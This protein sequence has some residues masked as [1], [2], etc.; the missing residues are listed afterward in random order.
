MFDQRKKELIQSVF[1]MAQIVAVANHK[2][3]V[4]KTTT[5]LNLGKALSL[6]GKKVLLIDIDPQANLTQAVGMDDVGVSIIGTFKEDQDLPLVQLAE[7]FFLAPS[8]LDL[9]VVETL[10]QSSVSGY[11]KLRNALQKVQD[12]FDYVLIDCPP[13]LN[14]LTINALIA[15]NMVMV[16]IQSEYLAVRGLTTLQN[17]IEETRKNLNP[18]LRLA[19]ILITQYDK[20]TVVKRA[21]AENVQATYKDLVFSTQIRYNVTLSE[22]ALA[23]KDI[24]TYSDKSN[25]AE[26]YRAL[27][28]EFLLRTGKH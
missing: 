27:A 5:T 20:R 15:A 19:G 16:V 1:K 9:S 4:G 21:I 18:S 7:T 25:G 28:E 13:N 14:T 23:N 11:F 26:D 10:L 2:G 22:A 3:G 24:F 8:D 6:L 17:L 12:Q